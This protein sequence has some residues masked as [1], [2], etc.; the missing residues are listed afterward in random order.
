[1]SRERR[2][3]LVICPP[4]TPIRQYVNVELWISS[5]D[6]QA[7][8]RR[9]FLMAVWARSRLQI[10]K[11]LWKGCKGIAGDG[12][13]VNGGWWWV[14]ILVGVHLHQRLCAQRADAAAEAAD[15][16]AEG[17]A[18]HADAAAERGHE[19]CEPAGE[20]VSVG[21]VRGKERE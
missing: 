5:I 19:L 9:I 13:R 10:A 2:S 21:G 14:F 8:R 17:G 12:R 1:M 16:R 20:S 15:A 18:Q 7:F 3:M 4:R 6:V 11:V